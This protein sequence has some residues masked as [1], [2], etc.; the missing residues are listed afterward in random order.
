MRGLDATGALLLVALGVAAA[1]AAA[2]LIDRGYFTPW[3]FAVALFVGAAF[4]VVG[5][6]GH[7][8]PAPHNTRVH[9]AAA[10]AAEHE[11]HA[12]ARGDT[13]TAP[14]HDATFPD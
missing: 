13:K 1:V 4:L 14:M 12:A 6:P 9:G 2:A 3:E 7:V 5:F 11:A 10:P 8:H